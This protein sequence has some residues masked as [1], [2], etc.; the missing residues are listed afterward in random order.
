MFQSMTVHLLG[1]GGSSLQQ[2]RH[3]GQQILSQR[4]ERRSFRSPTWDFYQ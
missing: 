2:L 3:V 1:A 4:L